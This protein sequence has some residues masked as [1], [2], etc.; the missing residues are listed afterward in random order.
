MVALTKD[1]GKASFALPL[2]LISNH[3]GFII[4]LDTLKTDVVELIGLLGQGATK[5]GAEVSFPHTRSTDT[6]L[7]SDQ[8]L[9]RNHYSTLTKSQVAELYQAYRHDHELFGFSPQ[10]FID[11]AQ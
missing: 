8:E 4:I 6:G 2:L 11:Y 5:D 3:P 10:K 1:S 9:L 7:S